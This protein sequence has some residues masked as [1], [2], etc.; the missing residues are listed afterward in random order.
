[1]IQKKLQR[2][3]LSCLILLV[4]SSC[5]KEISSEPKPTVYIEKTKGKYQLIRN[6]KPFY[7][8]GAAGDGRYLEELKKAG[9]NTIRV[10]DTIGLMEILD[11]AQALSLAVAVDIPLPK[12][13]KKFEYN[14]A[15][16]KEI[17]AIIA[18]TVRKYKDHPALLYWNLGNEI[19]YPVYRDITAF[20]HH[21][22]NLLELI[23]KI[24]K[25]HP[26][27]TTLAGLNRGRI[28]SIWMRSKKLDF[29]SLQ[30][31]GGLSRLQKRR[32]DF[33][34]LWD[35]PYVIS[36]WGIDGPWED[37]RTWWEAPIEETSS[38]KAEQI[39]QRHEQYIQSVRD[40]HLLGN[41]V[42][43]W[44]KK[45]EATPTWF[46]IFN[47]RGERIETAFV[48]QQIWS[49]EC[50]KYPGPSINFILLNKKGAADNVVLSPGGLGTAEVKLLG[51][52]Q[53]SLVGFWEI[54]KELWHQDVTTKSSLIKV[55]WQK[56]TK[57]SF[58]A[59]QNEG[60]YRLYL[61]LTNGS[62]Y[63]ATANIPFYVLNPE[64]EE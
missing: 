63:F 1:M 57:M 45:I 40:D 3:F 64:N 15:Y 31:F 56:G 8:K 54:K 59:P 23:H 22:N 19:S 30:T 49:D 41:F 26:V 60:P 44:S 7:I 61:H 42:F 24:D 55:P 12:Y 4:K 58:K 62:E 9:G 34:T 13:D 32:N 21:F 29:I 52:E 10:Y 39:R 16:T 25:N 14:T 48:M 51:K 28:N 50:A 43:Y 11:N 27:S 18:P 36:E 53:D 17:K 33:F 6:G 46:S 35:G 37:Y 5:S 20:V 2:V 47:E 38:K